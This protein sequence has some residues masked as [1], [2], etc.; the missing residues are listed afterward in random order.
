MN[1]EQITT[2]TT[3]AAMRAGTM[4][5]RAIAATTKRAPTRPKPAPR[6]KPGVK[7]V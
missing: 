5:A 3:I 4:P 6:A 7:R 2:R 1:P